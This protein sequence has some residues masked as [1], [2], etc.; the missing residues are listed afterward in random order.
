MFAKLLI[1][2]R[3]EIACRVIRTAA[4]MGIHTVAVYSEADAQAQHVRLA[5]EAIAIGPASARESYLDMD[6]HI[7]AAQKAGADAVHPGYGFLA[8]NADFADACVNADLTFVGPPADVIRAMGSK[9]VAKEI[10]TAAGVPVVAGY[11]GT[12]QRGFNLQSQADLIG[13]PLLIKPISGGGGK[14]M[15]I[16]GSAAEFPTAL[17][18][19]QREAAAAFGDGRVLIEKYLIDPRHVEFQ[20]FC[21]DHGNVVHL[22]ERDCS[23]QR[24]YQKVIEESPAPNLSPALRSQMGKAA[25][26]AAR[27][28]DYR[29][30]GTV[31]FLLTEDEDFY[32][33]EMN[34]RLQVEH[35]VT[36]L[37]TSQDLVE[38]Q[39]RIA[40]GEPL[41][42]LQHEI[43][44]HGHAIEARLYA[45]DP[46][47]EFLPAIGRLEHLHFPGTD[48]LVRIDTGVSA[49]DPVTMHYDPMLAKLIAW[50]ETRDAAL[51][52]LADALRMTEVVGLKTNREFLARLLLHPQFME[53]AI[54]TSFIDTKLPALILDKTDLAES[55]LA[56]V[57][58]YLLQS[59]RPKT[60]LIDPH[61]PWALHNG[62]RLNALSQQVLTI[63]HD[64]NPIEVTAEETVNGYLLKLPS[65]TL[66]AHATIDK[67]GSMDVN[68]NEWQRT[69]R[70]VDTELQIS[71]FLDGV[72]T[73]FTR[74][75]PV[76]E[77][78]SKMGTDTLRAPMPGT[79]TAVMVQV[80]TEVTRGTPLMVLEAM[81]ME[82]TITAPADGVV[83][84][85]HYTIGDL[86]PEEGVELLAIDQIE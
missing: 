58:L 56:C 23:L 24:R 3:G 48:P 40:T 49:G 42:L 17:Q 26:A 81:K 57:C 50:G 70:V 32:F 7:A 85:I 59:Q 75:Q 46:K 73:D 37:L 47:R 78:H 65:V 16:V 5:D 2:N 39:L 84:S 61:T 38:W 80:G 22:F 45:E 10:I 71:V 66:T 21:D 51:Y 11:Y 72:Q 6:K 12:D 76:T 82:H 67:T 15:R 77:N 33:I 54:A 28:V 30:A 60:A 35:P 74:Y 4:R 34:P 9:G 43:V 52:R 31:E 69:A 20:I 68:L 18:S 86:V 55:A 41:P 19:A 29:N 1:A 25:V 8:E 36:E 13:Y 64:G 79:V 62:W 63:V 83:A 14:G 44:P 27:S 53:G